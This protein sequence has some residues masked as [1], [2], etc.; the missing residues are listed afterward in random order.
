MK[1][2][3]KETICIIN[4][5]K[6]LAKAS[7]LWLLVLVGCQ[8]PPQ[9]FSDTRVM[10]GTYVEVISDDKRA[11]P[12]VFAE[13]ER[14]EDLL[15]KYRPNSDVSRLNRLGKVT[16]GSDLYF[17]LTK[18]KEYWFATDGAFDITVGPLMDLWGFTEKQYRQP[19]DEEIQKTLR[20][21]GANKIIFHPQNN[22]V[23]FNIPGMKIDLGA[24]GKGYAVD[25]AVKALRV[26]GVKNCLINAG[27]QV[28]CLGT[29]AGKPW[30][31]AIRDP[32]NDRLRGSV[33]CTDRSISTS[34]DYEQYFMVGKTRFSHI[35]DPRTGYPSRSKV[36][37]ATV[38]ASDGLTADFLS[39][40]LVVLGKE[41]GQELLKL[42]PGAQVK[43]IEK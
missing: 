31:V 27:G 36:I 9:M 34:G 16:V 3:D 11:A 39:T 19:S 6:V 23:E 1:I 32:R 17:L 41:K 24:I 40:S 33:T 28:Y 2:A 38:T 12:I 26:A 25:C 8:S 35:M 10:M 14:V 7:V 15:S 18:A 21:I 13:I 29:R 43:L 20:F 37:S 4:Y 30:R 22:V 42:F 5:F